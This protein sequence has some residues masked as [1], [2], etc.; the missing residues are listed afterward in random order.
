MAASVFDYPIPG[1]GGTQ[2]SEH[3]E[4][5]HQ[6]V[7][8]LGF[9]YRE[10]PAAV[11]PTQRAENAVADKAHSGKSGKKSRSIDAKGSAPK[12]QGCQ[13]K[14]RRQDRRD[15]QRNRAFVFDRAPNP[16]K[17]SL[18]YPVF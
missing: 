11:K 7:E 6:P 15:R 10:D 16:L 14:R 1:V 18:R 4:P 13:R 8:R 5:D 9:Q 3:G 17:L 2:K 12:N